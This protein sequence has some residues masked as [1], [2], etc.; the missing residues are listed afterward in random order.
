[1]VKDH[2]PRRGSMGFYPRKRAKSI[3]ARVRTWVDPLIGKPMLLGFA[4]YKAGMA[5][6][7]MIEDRPTSPLY[8][9]EIVV[10]VTIIDCPPLYVCGI[11]FYKATP[12]GLLTMTEVWANNIKEAHPD[13]ERV[14]TLPE[15][16]EFNIDEVKKKVLDNLDVIEEIRAIV[17]T[18]PRL[19]GIGK[20]TPEVF[21]I[22]I[23][24]VLDK[25]KLIEYAFSILGKDINVTDVFKEGWYVDVISITKGKGTAGVIK[26]FGVKEK[27]RWHKHRKGSRKIGS[28]GPQKPAVMFTTPMAGQLGFHQRTEYNKRILKIGL[29]GSEVTPAGGFKHYGV[30]KGPYVVL[31]GS[32][33]GPPKRL[34][35]MRFPVRPRPN[36]VWDKPQVLW[37]STK[38]ITE[39]PAV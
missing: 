36:L 13:V 6:V 14:V 30:I 9:K 27:P 3:V 35:K 28:V 1:M 39:V 38:P 17:A 20:K 37:I 7:V 16:L 32:V 24:G 2:R 25:V 22:P 11:R 8:G 23:G 19:S 12:Y 10:P 4:G 26:R 33:P 18:R 21:E 5:H 15:K 29:D 34:V 31:A